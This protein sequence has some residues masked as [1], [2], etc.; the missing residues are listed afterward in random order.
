MDMK[1]YILESLR[2]GDSKT[3]QLMKDFLIKEGIN[4][5]FFRVATV[6]ELNEA[7]E[8][9]ANDI[10]KNT[11]QPFIHFDCHSNQDGI[12]VIGDT[13]ETLVEWK[14]IRQMFRDVYINS[15]KKS[16]LSMSCCEGFYVSKLVAHNNPSPFDHVCGSI[17]KISF[18][19]S[20]DV[21]SR[22]YKLVSQGKD[23]FQA[24]VEVSNLP[25]LKHVK[26]L[27]VNSFTLF[28]IAID[29][30]I[31]QNCNKEAL[32]KQKK[33]AI[34]SIISEKGTIN[35]V[36]KAYLNYVFS[37]EGQKHLLQERSSTFFS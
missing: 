12:G 3:G 18:Q 26:F 15:G 24:C 16:V 28:K 25:E 14:D 31:D 10:S 6:D 21:F 20:F 2:R 8:S 35:H 22:M 17:E 32:E 30:Y 27:G 19:D 23:V 29:G 1:V 5:E 37:I 13:S 7:L 9:V 33:R 4:Q 11:E 34:Q 36:Q